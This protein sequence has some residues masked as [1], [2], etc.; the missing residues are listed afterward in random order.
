MKRA[1]Q[2]GGYDI[3]GFFDAEA[4]RY[5]RERYL[6]ETCDQLAYQSRR[7][8]ALDLLG[9]G[10]GRI[11]DIGAG[12][13]ILTADLRAR[14]FDVY[15]LDVSLEM[16]REC[17]R[18][19]GVEAGEPQLIEGRLPD[20]PF[21][22][23]TFDAAACIGVLAYLDDPAEGLREIR[24]VLRHDGVAVVQVS[25]SLCAAARLHSRLRRW[26]RLA[27]QLL[28]GKAY[29][30]LGIPLKHFRLGAFRRSLESV[31]LRPEAVALYDFR[32]PL[33][34]W[35]MPRTT[36]AAARWLQR[37]EYSKVPSFLAEGALIK[38]RAC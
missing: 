24:R 13:G 10:P 5:V 38:V 21:R 6:A 1:A 15:C 35:V 18:T 19:T 23:G 32:P 36:L 34:Q 37:F 28:G 20:L 7:R 30:H 26:Y 3:R 12:P 22:S 8:L 33:L 4:S 17:R 2:R 31:S 25:N 27:G 29:P 11:L 9:A 16:L 14:A